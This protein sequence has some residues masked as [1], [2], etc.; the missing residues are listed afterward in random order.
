[1]NRLDQR[2]RP[3]Y[4]SAAL[5]VIGLGLFS[6]S[7]AA[8]LPW[9]AAKYAGDGLWGLVVFLGVGFL[10]PRASTV[11]AAVLAT[12]FACGVETA[13]LFH[14]GWLD[15]VR[16]TR[17]GG[18]VLGT[19]DSA[20]AWADILAYQVGIVT[21]VGAEL[22]RRRSALASVVARTTANSRSRRVTDAGGER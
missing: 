16:R 1:M 19:P 17:L 20:F 8:G 12:A 7:E 4:A 15:A 11:W 9:A 18:L 14:P 3:G 5:A 21:G 10:L 2:S 13:Q 22:I 6:R